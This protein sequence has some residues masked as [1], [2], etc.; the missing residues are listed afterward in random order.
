[1]G[2]SD[3]RYQIIIVFIIINNKGGLS[4]VNVHIEKFAIEYIFRIIFDTII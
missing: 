1:M 3:K 2:L 4:M